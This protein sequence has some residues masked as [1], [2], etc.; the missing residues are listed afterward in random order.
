MMD[1]GIVA[2]FVTT[3]LVYGSAFAIIISEYYSNKI[4]SKYNKIS[5]K[6]TSKYNKIEKKIFM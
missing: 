4:T 1:G 6:I 3:G 5:N 2:V